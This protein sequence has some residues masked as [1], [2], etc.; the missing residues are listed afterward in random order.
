[1][2]RAMDQAVTVR[3]RPRGFPVNGGSIGI[4]SLEG[5]PQPPVTAPD[6]GFC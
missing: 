4:T 2:S 1:V 3:P 5:V 6:W